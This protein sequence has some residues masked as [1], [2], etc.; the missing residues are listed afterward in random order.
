VI[1]SCTPVTA[2]WADEAIVDTSVLNWM[3]RRPNECQ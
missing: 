2:P 1:F 3:R